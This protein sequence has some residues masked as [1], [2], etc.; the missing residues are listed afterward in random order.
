MLEGGL[1]REGAAS[2][3]VEDLEA[4][5]LLVAA[6]EGRS[7][8]LRGGG[9]GSGGITFALNCLAYGILL[10]VT[11]RIKIINLNRKKSLE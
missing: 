6:C 7:K 10:R 9:G 5:M 2:N 4:M 1:L 3:R 8:G 11:R